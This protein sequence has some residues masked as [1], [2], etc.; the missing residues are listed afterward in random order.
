MNKQK[1]L[2]TLELENNFSEKEVKNKYKVFLAKHK[3]GQNIN[4]DQI[5]EAYNFLLGYE[6]YEKL[7]KN[8]KSYKIRR[9]LF[10]YLSYI[11]I[12]IAIA[13]FIAW[14]IVPKL[15]EK[16]PDLSISYVGNYYTLEADNMKKILNEGIN[17]IEN[18]MIEIIY[19]DKNSKD[20]NYDKAGR[21]KLA[22]IIISNQAD[23]F[24]EDDENYVFMLSDDVLMPLDDIIPMLEV[25]I[26]ESRY[27]YG[28]D[29]KD[30]KKKIFGIDVSNNK[31]IV[32]TAF[33]NINKIYSIAKKSEHL[34]KVI[35]ATN[36][37]LKEGE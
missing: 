22:G 33:G 35:I 29:T 2:Q 27:I 10:H 31:L 16:K 5:T 23:I 26:D 17:D 7:D 14:L 11:I 34:D 13:G 9:F 30:H 3:D 6:Q 28:I 20:V 36:L 37:L 8:S 18:L 32:Q 21:V 15:T 24:I 19:L 1:A 25:K 12:F 4:I